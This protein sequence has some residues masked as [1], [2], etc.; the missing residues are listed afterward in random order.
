VRS[1]DEGELWC[2]LVEKAFAKYFG[3]YAAIEG[4]YPGSALQGLTGGDTK[5]LLTTK[6]SKDELW[7]RIREYD[8]D[9]WIMGCSTEGSSD[10]E[11]NNM[12]I[13]GNHAYSLI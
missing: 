7:S 2:S 6:V 1:S 8:K 4:R 3:G 13:V 11:I 10:R 12:G 5:M 9:N